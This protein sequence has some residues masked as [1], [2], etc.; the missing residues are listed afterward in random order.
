M[1]IIKVNY[2]KRFLYSNIIRVKSV[3]YD[4]YILISILIT[5]YIPIFLIVPFLIHF[6]PIIVESRN[7]IYKI[8]INDDIVEITYSHFYK[9]KVCF[10]PIN[11]VKIYE[12]FGSVGNL[13]SALY[14]GEK[15]NKTY[16]KKVI[17]QYKI[18]DWAKQ[19]NIDALKRMLENKQ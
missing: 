13:L 5:F 17:T 2:K 15:T 18:C 14:I 9:T 7:Y 11:S 10:I 6:L 19:E 4:F 12:D 3:G 1:E 8:N 16:F